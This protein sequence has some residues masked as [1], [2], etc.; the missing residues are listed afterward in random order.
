MT[1]WTAAHLPDLEG[2]TAIVTGATGGI[3][4]VAARELARVGAHIVLAVRDTAKGTTVAASIP[5]DTEVRELDV[6]SLASVRGF[7][8]TWSRPIDILINN[9]GI[10]Q[11]P[12]ARTEEGFESQLATNYIGPFVLTNLL[13]PHI[14]DRVVVV[15]SQLHRMGRLHLDDLNGERRTYDGFAAYADSKLD[16]TLFS[17]EL[18]RRLSAAGSTVRSIVAH[19]GIARTNLTAHRGGGINRLGALL[20]DAE[21]GALPLLYAATEDVP[22][23]S[24]VGP[25][26]LGGVKGY[27]VVRRAS[28]AALDAANA[29]KLWDLTAR[30]TGVDFSLPASATS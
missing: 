10:M 12:L 27:P 1:K 30:L 26:G 6:S 29:T 25:N 17:L 14:I 24:Y 23:N 18:Q 15:S 4:L 8:S 13:L 19:P 9:A 16:L 11:V 28:K 21:H 20:N 7:A 2:R 22:G 5:G 3:G